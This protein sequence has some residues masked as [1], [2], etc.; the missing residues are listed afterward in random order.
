MFA[1]LLVAI[2]TRA[3]L[4]PPAR[5]SVVGFNMLIV[6][7]IAISYAVRFEQAGLTLLGWFRR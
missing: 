5:A 6:F 2:L 3:N 7:F 4:A 1:Y